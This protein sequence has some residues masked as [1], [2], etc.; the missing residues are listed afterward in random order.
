MQRN[1]DFYKKKTALLKNASLF[2]KSREA[3]LCK[4]KLLLFMKNKIEFFHEI[5]QHF[6]IT[7]FLRHFDSFK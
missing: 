4:I 6:A 1:F 5:Q 2:E 7:S 3:Y